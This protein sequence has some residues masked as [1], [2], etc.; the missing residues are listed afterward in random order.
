MFEF[1]LNLNWFEIYLKYFMIFGNTTCPL[2]SDS[3]L[4]QLHFVNFCVNWCIGTTS[5]H[6]NSFVVHI[7]CMVN[8]YLPC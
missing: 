6:C 5:I 7:M 2:E 3:C 8:A 1:K 4:N